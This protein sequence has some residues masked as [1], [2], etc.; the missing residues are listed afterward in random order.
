MSCACATTFTET[1]S[2]ANSADTDQK[3]ES[4]DQGQHCLV[5]NTFTSTFIVDN[6]ILTFL[7]LSFSL[8]VN[9]CFTK[10]QCTLHKQNW[11]VSPYLKKEKSTMHYSKL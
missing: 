1:A 4:S 2:I 5:Y 9:N 3:N 7:L 8:R 11:I 6:F 10:E